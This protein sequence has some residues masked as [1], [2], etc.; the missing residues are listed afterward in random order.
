MTGVIF[1]LLWIVVEVIFAVVF[2][3]KDRWRHV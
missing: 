1:I 2:L 3:G